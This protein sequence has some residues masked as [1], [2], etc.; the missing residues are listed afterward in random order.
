MNTKAAERKRIYELSSPQSSGKTKRK[1][2]FTPVRKISKASKLNSKSFEKINYFEVDLDSNKATCSSEFKEAIFAAFQH[3]NIT[4]YYYLE[5]QRIETIEILIREDNVIRDFI[6]AAIEQINAKL[7]EEKKCYC[8]N[9]TL[10]EYSIKIVK[11]NGMPKHDIPS[12][13]IS[14]LYHLIN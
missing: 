13:N 2:N 11:K 12:I 6:Q 8:F 3:V 7:K 5:N 4:L 1:V 9:P 10:S 14:Y